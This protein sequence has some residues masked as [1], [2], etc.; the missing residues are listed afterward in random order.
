MITKPKSYPKIKFSIEPETDA[1]FF[2][3]GRRNEA[4][5]RHYP[6]MKF[7]LSD[8]FNDCRDKII[9]GFVRNYYE[10]NQKSIRDGVSETRKK[11]KKISPRYF[12]LV[13]K[14]FYGHPWPRGNYRGMTCIWGSYPRVIK[15]KYFAFPIKRDNPKYKHNDLRVIAHEMLHFIT[16]D[17]LQKKYILQP[18]EHGNKDNIFWQFTESLNVLIENEMFWRSFSGPFKSKPYGD[19]AKLYPKMKKVWDKNKDLDNLIKK[20]FDLK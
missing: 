6:I 5:L 9:K 8:D 15:E 20:T 11:W 2:Y 14:I 17:Y 12:R 1:K 13:D 4:S 3:M 16:Y 7:I 10:L 19:C 18:S